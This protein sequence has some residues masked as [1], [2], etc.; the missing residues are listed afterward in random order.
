[1]MRHV[2]I[3]LL[4]L[5]L[6]SCDKESLDKEIPLTVS[7]IVGNWQIVSNSYSIGGPI[8]TEEIENGG[9]YTFNIDSSFAFTNSLNTSLNYSGT[10]T[11]EEDLLTLNY[12]KNEEDVTRLLNPDF[13]GNELKLSPGG[14]IICIEGCYFTLRKTNE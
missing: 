2:S 1:M 12:T 3:L 10:Y 7:E 14:E 9:I 8:I 11:L 4:I 6:F 13:N 5:I